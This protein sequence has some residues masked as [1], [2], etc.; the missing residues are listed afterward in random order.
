MTPL[1]D[2]DHGPMFSIWQDAMV[3]SGF[4]GGSPLFRGSAE[5]VNSPFKK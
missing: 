2:K 1:A 5:L 3:G 4:G